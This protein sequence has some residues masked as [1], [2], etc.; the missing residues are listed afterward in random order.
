ML[1][2]R[3]FLTSP[4]SEEGAR[5]NS[6]GRRSYGGSREPKG[7]NPLK[8]GED[9]TP[10]SKAVVLATLTAPFVMSDCLPPVPAKLV[11]EIMK[12]DNIDMAE[13]LRDN[14]PVEAEHW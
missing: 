13:L 14:I 8:R 7:S 4:P 12:G 6:R 2:C 1:R 5:L 10:K 9:P 3:A 11:A